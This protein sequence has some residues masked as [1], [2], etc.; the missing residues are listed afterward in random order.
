MLLE[1]LDI[2]PEEFA[3]GTGWEIKSEGA[4]QA[5]LCVPLDRTGSFD[6]PATAGRLRMALVH[7]P[8][9]GLWA[10]GPAALGDRALVSARAPELALDDLEGHSFRLSSLRGS[11]VVLV[12][13]APY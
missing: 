5:E 13:W 6:V 2:T 11:K 9:A 3:A 12:S 7:E 10:L 8:A 1:S 4:C